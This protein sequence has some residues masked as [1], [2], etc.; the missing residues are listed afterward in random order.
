MN[1]MRLTLAAPARISDRDLT[2]RRRGK[3]VKILGGFMQRDEEERRQFCLLKGGGKALL[4]TSN[5]P[6]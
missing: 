3:K 4:F 2:Q 1:M 5:P 6:L